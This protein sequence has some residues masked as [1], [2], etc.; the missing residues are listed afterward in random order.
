MIF[1]VQGSHQHLDYILA[2][3]AVWHLTNKFQ[4]HNI[5]IFS[6]FIHQQ[7]NR[8]HKSLE[9]HNSLSNILIFKLA[10]PWNSFSTV[11][12][13]LFNF[14]DFL[15]KLF[16]T[17]DLHSRMFETWMLV[18][19]LDCYSH[20]FS[21]QTNM[22]CLDDL[23]RNGQCKSPVVVCHLP[24]QYLFTMTATSFYYIH[25]SAANHFLKPSRFLEYN[26]NV[27]CIPHNILITQYS[28][29]QTAQ[30]IINHDLSL[31]FLC[32]R[33][34]LVAHN[35]TYSSC[36]DHYYTGQHVALILSN[37]QMQILPEI[38]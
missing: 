13:Y 21:L 19:V 25:I 8:L 23:T 16:R 30:S 12:C 4:H 36:E 11:P 26:F 3:V 5:S 31:K 10:H 7:S 15:L 24:T 6:E 17:S 27:I 33:A 29:Q 28:I 22:H 38:L 34:K 1:K 35:E 37:H 9:G 2:A 20:D 18:A 14:H 32:H